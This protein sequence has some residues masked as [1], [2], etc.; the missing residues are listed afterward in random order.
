MVKDK[1]ERRLR[2][3]HR[4]SATYRIPSRLCC[5]PTIWFGL[6]KRWL[7]REGFSV[8]CNAEIKE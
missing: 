3:A 6:R 4:G 8:F 2:S 5:G 1:G 7:K